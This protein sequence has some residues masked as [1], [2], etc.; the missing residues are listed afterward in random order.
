VGAQR[1]PSARGGERAGERLS[2]DGQK[3][4]RRREKKKKKK[5]KKKKRHT[6]GKMRK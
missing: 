3:P 4:L 6:N 1:D 5:K 2:D